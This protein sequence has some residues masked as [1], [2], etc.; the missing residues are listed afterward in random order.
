MP[1]EDIREEVE[2]NQLLKDLLLQINS[3][4]YNDNI[5][6]VLEN[7]EMY[8]HSLIARIAFQPVFR[9]VSFDFQGDNNLPR[10]EIPKDR[11][12]DAL[13]GSTMVSKG[14]HY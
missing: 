6:D 11:Y 13:L 7:E 8:L 2:L 10:L 4:P 3:V 1:I 9:E 14:G 12:C 5:L